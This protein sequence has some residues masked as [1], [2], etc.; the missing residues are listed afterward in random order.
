MQS[1]FGPFLRQLRQSRGL[2]QVRVAEQAGIGRVTLGRWESGNQQPRLFELEAVL[3]ALGTTKDEARQASQLLGRMGGRLQ[4][5]ASEA[6]IG[7]QTGIGPR[8]HGGSLLLAMRLRRGL[9]QDEAAAKA[10]VAVRTL[11]RWEKAEAWPSAT[12]LHTLCYVLG[13]H[14]QEIAALS[15]G[16]A[17]LEFGAAQENLSVG[18]LYE[19]CQALHHYAGDPQTEALKELGFLALEAQAWPLAARSEGGR[20]IL[21]RI[22]SCHANY[23]STYERWNEGAFYA[24]RA[25][26]LVGCDQL[27]ERGTIQAGIAAARCATYRGRRPSPKRGL[28]ILRYWLDC[29]RWPVFE[30]WILSDMAKYYALDGDVSLSLQLAQRA[31]EV[32]ARQVVEASDQR[33]DLYLRE[34]DEAEILF[35]TG[36]ASHVL[37]IV[38]R[39]RNN[40]QPEHVAQF[41]LLEADACLS[42]Q[43]VSRAN[44]CVQEA[45][46]LIDKWELARFQPRAQKLVKRL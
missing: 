8:P 39:E 45:L 3:N 27:P 2:S 44:D 14:P 12:Q 11:R 18:E 41:R 35:Q 37:D 31:R 22:Y 6:R 7:A 38:E 23:Y 40:L 9:S 28:E 20:Q 5:M 42:L 24:D 32:A 29:A 46:G 10:G 25:L 34:L 13:A 21:S 26:E 16:E 19:R 4:E 36:E 43:L 17:K 30:S 1:H 33:Y 15:S